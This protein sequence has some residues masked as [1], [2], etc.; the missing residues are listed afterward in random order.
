VQEGGFARTRRAH[1]AAE[2]ALLHAQADPAQRMNLGFAHHIRFLQ[3]RNVNDH[4]RH[5]WG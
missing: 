4:R 5:F 3:I 1:Q 2:L